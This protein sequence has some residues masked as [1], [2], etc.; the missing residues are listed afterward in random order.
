LKPQKGIIKRE[1]R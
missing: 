1:V